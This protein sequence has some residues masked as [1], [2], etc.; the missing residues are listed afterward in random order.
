MLHDGLLNLMIRSTCFGH[1]YAHHQEFA[2]IQMAPACGTSPWLWQVA[3]LVH[4]CRFKADSHISCRAR[5]VPLPCRAAKGLECV[6]PHLIY[7]VRPCLIHT[8]HAAPVSRQDQSIHLKATAQR[9]RRDGLWATSLLSASS[10]YHTE[11]HE[12]YYQKHANLR[13]RWP[14]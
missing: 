14:V 7:T 8:C 6:F 5:A 10:G 13:C 12:F 1:Y 2:T 9:G 4:G 3:G 11:F